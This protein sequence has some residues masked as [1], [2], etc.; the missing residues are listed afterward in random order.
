LKLKNK[1]GGVMLKY[2]KFILILYFALFLSCE[3][4]EVKRDA[5][6]KKVKPNFLIIVADDLGYT[7]IEPFGG[8]INTPNLSKLAAEGSMLTNFHVL[9][10]QS[11]LVLCMIRLTFPKLK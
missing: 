11:V 4:S 3:N 1:F 8:E 10:T 2:F 9:P 6:N 7:D 5:S